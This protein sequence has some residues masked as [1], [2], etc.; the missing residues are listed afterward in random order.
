MLSRVNRTIKMTI[1]LG[2]VIFI[3]G[4]SPKKYIL[5][6]FDGV[7]DSIEYVYLTD[8]DP[9]LVKESFPFNLKIIEILLDQNPDDRDMLLTALSSFTMYAYGFIME[10][11]EKLVLEDYSAGNEIYN[12]ANKLFN[13]ALRYGVHGIEL[14]YPEFTNW[15]EK[16]EIDK[17][18]FVE[19][20]IAYLYWISAALGGLISSSQG[21]PIYVVDLP[22][23]GW[24]LEKSME[25]D[26]SWNGGALYSAMIPFTMSRPDAV[27]NREQV[28]RDYF[29]KA[30]Q[31]SSGEDCSVYVRFAESVCIKNQNK[32]AFI[33]NLNYVLNF[34]IESAKELR[35]ANTMAQFRA[36]WLM[37]RVDEL[38]Y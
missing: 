3:I 29:T 6:Q 5:N 20:D 21:N 18:P 23:I 25:I 34:N 26:S 37:G 33:E 36:K 13:R 24:L 15:W 12:R 28:A 22:K 9:Q 10:D 4:C 27:K 32:D 19:K 1:T 35:L 30:V 2:M 38:F 16:G 31:A 11:A 8:D 17:N 14:K 7:F